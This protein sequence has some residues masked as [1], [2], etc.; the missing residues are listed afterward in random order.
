MKTIQLFDVRANQMAEATIERVGPEWVATFSDTSH[1]VKF[2]Y[3][4]NIEELRNLIAKHNEN[5]TFSLT[6]EMIQEENDK[7]NALLESL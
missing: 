1:F 6:E 7:S 5:N 2:P 4:D 3:S